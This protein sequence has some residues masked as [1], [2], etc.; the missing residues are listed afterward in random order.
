MENDGCL[1]SVAVTLTVEALEEEMVVINK[2][3]DEDSN[4]LDQYERLSFEVRLN[5][6]MFGAGF[7]GAE[8]GEVSTAGII[9][10]LKLS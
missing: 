5:Q 1:I 6:A 10:W 7:F 8:D 9:Y 2:F 3:G 4:L